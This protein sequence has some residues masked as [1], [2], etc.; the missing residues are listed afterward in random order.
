MNE[1]TTEKK[2]LRE[3]IGRRRSKL[4]PE[5]VAQTSLV[6]QRKASELE[7]T[8]GS[9][10]ACCYVALRN[11]VQTDKIMAGCWQRGQKV[12]VPAYSE[13]DG[14]YVLSWLGVGDE[15]VAGR[16][17]IGEPSQI[18]PAK[19]GDVDV[20]FIPGVA[21]DERCNRVGRGGGHYDRMLSSP[22]ASRVFKIGLAF[23]FQVFAAVPTDADDVTMD[24]IVTED[25][26][27]CR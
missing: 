25:R 8:I 11:E 7:R 5:R 13:E 10:A 2:T 6:I 3:A 18:V 22:A 26:L 23:D 16:L 19:I 24:V 14:G 27:L 20:V 4:S 1:M 21:F 12:C 9:A 15:L 17:G